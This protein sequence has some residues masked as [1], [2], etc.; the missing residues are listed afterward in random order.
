MNDRG[1][2]AHP[3][4]GAVASW[5]RM[6]PPE[7]LVRRVGGGHAYGPE[8]RDGVIGAWVQ[9]THRVG[10][11]VL[12]IGAEIQG[13]VEVATAAF[14][15]KLEDH[16]FRDIEEARAFL[17][18][19]FAHIHERVVEAQRQM[20]VSV[21]ALAW[22]GQNAVVCHLGEARAYLHR[23]RGLEVVTQD[24]TLSMPRMGFILMK[25]LGLGADERHETRED[26][27]DA[28]GLVLCTQWVHRHAK[29]RDFDVERLAWS[30]P[31][32]AMDA[33]R[34]ARKDSPEI[35]TI[36]YLRFPAV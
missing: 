4:R 35:G 5:V 34:R 24:D 1:V 29:G 21:T 8:R 27:R 10:G 20:P 6:G 19:V 32:E 15:D 18:D 16:S 33:L 12:V 3:Y 30:R 25:G 2:E 26:L 9:A 28:R 31:E 17:R 11:V 22:W 7:L 36:A 13:D 14:E 23:E